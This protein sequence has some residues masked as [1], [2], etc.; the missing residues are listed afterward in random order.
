MK[1]ILAN[2]GMTPM[3]VVMAAIEAGIVDSSGLTVSEAVSEFLSSNKNRV[4]PST[5]SFYHD[6]LAIFADVFGDKPIRSVGPNAIQ[7]YVDSLSD[8]AAASRFRAIRRLFRF[9][10]KRIPPWIVN[11][12]TLHI[13]MRG[14][15]TKKDT[16]KFLSV[17]EASDAMKVPKR[18]QYAVALQLFAGIRPDEVAGENKPRLSWKHINRSERKIWVP[19]EVSKTAKT[20]LLE[21]LP[22]NLWEWLDDGPKDGPITDVLRIQ[23]NRQAQ[24]A[25]SFLSRDFKRIKVWP[26]DGLRHS[27][28]TYHLALCSDPGKTSMLAGWEGSTSLLYSTYAGRVSRAQAE[29]YFNIRPGA[30][31][32]SGS[33]QR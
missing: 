17:A 18:Y 21:D 2:S 12:P 1:Q 32:G 25:A 11:D 13:D 24:V 27:F 4:R 6:N 7:A 5:L 29:D 20:R 3:E 28:V 30:S 14:R 19:A 8:G 33:R 15:S 9:G 10:M 31:S 22:E 26:R 23:I 16:T